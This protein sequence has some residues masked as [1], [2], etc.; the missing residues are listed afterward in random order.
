MYPNI[1]YVFKD[2]FGVEW[3]ALSF[4]NTFGLMVAMGFVVSAIVLSAEL[5]R[6]EKQGLLQPREEYI[7]VGQPASFI[8]LL[9]NFLTGFIFA[10]KLVGLFFNKPEDMNPQEYIF[11]RDG[12][13]LGGLALGL[14]LAGLKWWDKNKQKL[15]DEHSLALGA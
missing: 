13:I 1:Y 6:K 15:P 14:L 5:K 8:E 12:N 11:S 4:L 9:I 10:Y 2:W 7:T 3:K